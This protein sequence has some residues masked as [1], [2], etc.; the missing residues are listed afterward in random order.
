MRDSAAVGYILG[1]DLGTTYSAAATAEHGL[2]EVFQLGTRAAA[3]PSVVAIRETGERLVGEP[4]ERRAVS[5]STRVA[6]EFKRRLGDSTSIIIGG[7][8]Y[9]AQSLTAIL[10]QSIYSQV[11]AERGGP[12]DRLVVTH[13]ASYGAYKLDLLRLAVQE[14][15]VPEALLVA[16]PQGAA[17]Y[18]ARQERIEPGAIVAV[19]DFGGGTFDAA[20][21]RRT[22]DGFELIG[23][24]EGLDRVGGIDV[25]EAVFAHVDAMIGGQIQDMD[26]TDPHEV[27][28]VAD[29]RVNCRDTKEALSAD[30]DVAIAV[31]LPSLHT[32]VRLTRAELESMIR[33]RIADTIG[34]LERSVRSAGLTFADLDRTL[35]VGGSSRIPLVAQ[36]VAEATRG[37]VAV[38]ANPKHSISLGAAAI[39]EEASAPATPEAA[40]PIT[41]RV[42]THCLAGTDRGE[43]TG[44]GDIPDAG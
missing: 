31:A 26:P 24:P 14:A 34:V 20:V 6:R 13:P 33:P 19:Y 37:R 2:L 30:T 23:T 9:S 15:G 25:D 21:L 11:A 39:G 22:D 17:V 10:L 12:P 38:D 44:G 29:L 36:M 32:E 40:A 28:A 16:E 5:D 18:Y 3:I 42:G 35:L 4:A 41:R 1:V 7:T 27:S 8:P 43:R